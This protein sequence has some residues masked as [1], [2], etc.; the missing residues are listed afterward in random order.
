MKPSMLFRNHRRVNFQQCV[1]NF[2]PYRSRELSG[3]AR[4]L[5]IGGMSKQ[6]LNFPRSSFQNKTYTGLG[7]SGPQNET[8]P[9]LDNLMKEESDPRIQSQ[10]LQA[11]KLG[12]TETM[13]YMQTESMTA[14]RVET[15]RALI[16][17]IIS[18]AVLVCHLQND[19][20]YLVDN[21][22]WTGKSYGFNVDQHHPKYGQTFY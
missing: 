10:Y 7:Q 12:L 21:E 5:G 4:K 14:K 19:Q 1:R 22:R 8:L 15:L 17:L 2:K 18:G 6:V 20:H 11:Y 16:R 13:Q 3:Q 9:T